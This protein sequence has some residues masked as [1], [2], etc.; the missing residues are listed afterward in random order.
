VGKADGTQLLRRPALEARFAAAVG[1]RLTLVL[2]DAGYGKSTLLG[3]PLDGRRIARHTIHAPDRQAPR[4]ASSVQDAMRAA[5]VA[6]EPI[7][8]VG[9]F[10]NDETAS[11]ELLA[12]SI[13]QGLPNATGDVVLVLDDLHE[14]PV[15]SGGAHLVEALVRQAPARLHIA[16]GSRDVPPFPTQRLRGRGEVTELSAR[17]LAFLPAEIEQLARMALGSVDTKLIDALAGATGGWPAAVRL[18]I[19]AL[20]PL[21]PSERLAAAAQL[22]SSA[23]S[24]L[25]Y[26]AEEVIGHQSTELRELLTVTSLLE[27]FS[28]GMLRT[29]G[30]REP[31]RLIA[32]LERRGLLVRLDA[33]HATLHQLVR[34]ATLDRLPVSPRRRRAL[35]HRAVDWHAAAGEV[36]LA[37]RLAAQAGETSQIAR[38][39][40]ERGETLIDRGRS[41]LVLETAARLPEGATNSALSEIVGQA[42]AARGEWDEAR[43]AFGRAVAASSTDPDGHGIPARLAWRLGA[44]EW[45]RGRFDAAGNVLDRA[46][47]D[48]ARPRDA[49]RV[50]ATLAPIL[51]NSGE[52]GRARA[53]ATRAFDLA[54]MDPDPR[55]L[56][57]AHIAMAMTDPE[58]RLEDRIEHFRRALAF[59]EAEGDVAQAIRIRVNLATLAGPAEG[60]R[61]IT[62][63]VAMA[64]TLGSGVRLGLVLNN[65][66]ENLLGLGRYDEAAVDLRR[67]AAL[68]QAGGSGRVGWALMNHGDVARERGD[69]GLARALYADALR[70]GEVAEDAQSVIGASA[71]LARL[72]SR[73]DPAAAARHAARAV[74]RSRPLGVHVARALLAAG[75]VAVLV[76]RRDEAHGVAAE[77]LEAARRQGW[78]PDA[79]EALELR[80]AAGRDDTER[81]TSLEAAASLWSEIGNAPARLRVELALA[82]LDRDSAATRHVRRLLERAG[83]RD[84]AGGAAGLLATL[85]PESTSRVEVRTLGGFEVAIRGATV[86]VSAWRSR[87]SRDLLKILICRRG[88][89]AARDELAALLWPGEQGTALGPRLSVTASLLRRVLEDDAAAADVAVGADRQHLWLNRSSLLIDVEEFMS[90]AARGLLGS[91]DTAAGLDLESAERLYAGDFLEDE[92]YVDWAVGL[93]E[94]ART[95]YIS[96]A[97]RLAEISEREGEHDRAIQYMLRILEHDPYDE[98]AHLR[99]V[100]IL[101]TVGRH[102]EARRAFRIYVGRMQEIGIEPT[103]Y[104][105]DR[106]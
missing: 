62:P 31:G 36:D 42:H 4:L 87:K 30:I 51:W 95:T 85:P 76:G 69:L 40:L 78:P 75:W 19:E 100:G 55:T 38:L 33:E 84:R 88:R 65:R 73:D 82:Y 13:A 3:V 24:I 29:L 94:E 1:Q 48:D 54:A 16:I 5:G 56:A 26:L 28:A 21:Q 99:L 101:E 43:A 46:T 59:A 68:L 39:L 44:V 57:A 77:A 45:E 14:L 86:P 60:L 49:A 25:D 22:T 89:P 103:A 91:D 98:P 37:L 106:T 6:V 90:E 70:H 93:R 81:R 27:R 79:A 66:G 20:R 18:A 23:G 50:L 2:A 34:A 47:L 11:H 63:A 41:E 97:R 80:A 8:E 72:A 104:P 102:G 12:S 64:E 7:S 53:M 96:V 71:G 92:P 58:Q 10:A 15:G 52:P 83:V 67:A 17:D 105:A 9:G 35:I 74:D 61:T 32:D